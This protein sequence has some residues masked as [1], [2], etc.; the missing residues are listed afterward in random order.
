MEHAWAHPTS[1]HKTQKRCVCV[2]L[3]GWVWVW[4]CVCGASGLT[5]PVCTG[6]RGGR[7]VCVPLMCGRVC[8]ASGLTPPVCTGCKRGGVG[9]RVPIDDICEF[10]HSIGGKATAHQLLSSHHLD[11]LPCTMSNVSLPHRVICMCAQLCAHAHTHT[12][13]GPWLV[14]LAHTGVAAALQSCAA[15]PSRPRL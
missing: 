1:L 6:C 15:P 5:P 12:H 13:R 8:G 4:V 9:V 3:G 11:V 10:A 14:A 2:L 7:C